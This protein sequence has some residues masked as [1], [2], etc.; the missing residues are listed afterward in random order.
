MSEQ[1]QSNYEVLLD[2]NSTESLNLKRNLEALGTAHKNL[3]NENL[4]LLQD[5]TELKREISRLSDD[6]AH[7]SSREI[8]LENQKNELMSKLL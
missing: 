5:I 1:I 3:E 4:G 8:A 7:Q 2:E 6:M